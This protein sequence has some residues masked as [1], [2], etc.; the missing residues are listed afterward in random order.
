MKFLVDENVPQAV[1][2]HLQHKGHGVVDLKQTEYQ[3]R[4]D[5]VVFSFARKQKLILLTYDQDFLSGQ[6]LGSLCIVVC[7]FGRMKPVDVLPWIDGMLRYLE[8][9]ATNKPYKLIIRPQSIEVY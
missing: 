4:S 7:Q 9:H 6:Y 1:L 2:R 3:G 5:K 8:A